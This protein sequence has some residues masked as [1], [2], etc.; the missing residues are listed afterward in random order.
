MIA[1]DVSR[2]VFV[3]P[4]KLGKF[5]SCDWYTCVVVSTQMLIGYRL[6]VSVICIAIMWIQIREH[7]LEKVVRYFTTW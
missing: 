1:S 4:I 3:P 5:A 6:V 7:S 2:F